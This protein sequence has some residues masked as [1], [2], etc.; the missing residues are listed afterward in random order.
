MKRLNYLLNGLSALALIVLFSQCTPKTDNQ[1]AAMSS[2]QASGELSGM[3]IAY[4]EV[5]TLL[6]KY[7]LSVDLN[8]AMVKKSENVR[9]RLNQK[10]T[11]LDKQKQEFQAKVQNGAY[12]S[13]ERAQSEYNR[14]AKL[15]Q[16]LQTLANTLQ[17]E[18]VS[19]QDKNS[20]LLR[21]SIS[22]FLRDYNK[23]KGYSLI[24]SNTGF[25]NLLYADP[26]YNITKEI[27]AGLNARYSAPIQ[28]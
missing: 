11:D 13:Q 18:L 6:L 7:N 10:A 16:D 28:K 4:V 15:E 27:I 23:T 22:A 9:L 20:L 8:E 12:A 17:T 3:K 24:I 5:D 19:E 1:A 26:Q 14:I 2:T 25:D 21:D